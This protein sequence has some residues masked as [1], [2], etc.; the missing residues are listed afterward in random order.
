MKLYCNQ[1]DWESE[2]ISCP[3]HLARED[4]VEVEKTRDSLKRDTTRNSC[5]GYPDC[6]TYND[7]SSN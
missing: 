4:K 1:C 6:T 5:Q 7:T 2:S 3:Y